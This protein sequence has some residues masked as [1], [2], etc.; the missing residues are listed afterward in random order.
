MFSSAIQDVG[1]LPIDGPGWSMGR[2]SSRWPVFVAPRR[3]GRQDCD[4]LPVAPR[5]CP[6][7]TTL[8]WLPHLSRWPLFSLQPGSLLHGCCFLLYF[9]MFLSC[10]LFNK[11]FEIVCWNIN[12]GL[13]YIDS[14]VLPHCE[15]TILL[16]P[17]IFSVG[18]YHCSRVDLHYTKYDI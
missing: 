3:I 7:F 1:S 16:A 6:L 2:P 11:A 4:A 14:I 8:S 17:K 5:G 12:L 18:A 10:R 15:F 9:G 13:D